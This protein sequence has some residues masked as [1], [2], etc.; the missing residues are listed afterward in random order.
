MVPAEATRARIEVR[1]RFPADGVTFEPASVDVP[2]EKAG[3]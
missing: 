1:F 3:G 2:V